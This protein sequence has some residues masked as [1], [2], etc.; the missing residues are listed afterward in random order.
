MVPLTL[1]ALFL[2]TLLSVPSVFAHDTLASGIAVRSAHLHQARA[3]FAK[4]SG[5]LQSRDVIAHRV[6][7]R[8]ELVE[9]HLEKRRVEK[10][11]WIPM[12]PVT[13]PG[14]N[15]GA[16]VLTPEVMV[17]PYYVKEEL[18]R[19]DIRKGEGE[20]GV[21]L[22]LDL[23]FVDF[24]TCEPVT[25]AMIDL[26]HCNTTGLYSGFASE[27]TTGEHFNRGLQPTDRRGIMHMITSFPGW[28][29]MRATHIHAIHIGGKVDRKKRI[30][31]GGHVTH[32]GQL[33]FPESLLTQIDQRLPYTK[34]KLKE[35]VRND[36]DFIYHQENTGYNAVSEIQML[37]DEM[38][39][40]ILASISVG[41]NLKASYNISNMWGSGSS[42]PPSG[43]TFPPGGFPTGPP[44]GMPTLLTTTRTVDGI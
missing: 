30:Y 40:G 27:K 20:R 31:Q 42:G 36:D 8:A 44:G 6:A 16:C 10:R 26:W 19:K 13:P 23:Q 2:A 35:R 12:P 14:N 15:T 41:I 33:F 43:M 7:R 25:N 18:I 9:S 21:P 11:Q 38:E 32:I 17:G 22:L 3:A 1:I 28:Y 5:K 29:D 34:N 24:D 39:D 37:G 4:C